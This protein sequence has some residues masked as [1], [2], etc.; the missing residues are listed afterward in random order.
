MGGQ[1]SDFSSWFPQLLQGLGH[2]VEYSIL[3]IV[4]ATII[5]L[6][7][8]LMR[9]SRF[10][11]WRAIS[12]VY[13]EI[14]RGTPLLVQLTFIVFGLSQAMPVLNDIFGAKSYP[15]I[16]AAAGLALNEGAYITEIV[17]AGILGVDR[18][19]R[20]AAESIG[21]TRYQ[22]MRYII[23]PQA[24]K[25]MIPPL[26]NQFAQ[27]IKDTSLLAPIGIVELMYQGQIVVSNNF[28]SFAVYG[29]VAI[30]YFV[31]IFIV[32]RIAGYLERRLQIDQR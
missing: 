16:G 10:W 18:G 1:T 5:G 27:T 15:L 2:T 8:A 24:F 29:T 13:V 14:F 28:Q 6:I 9:L 3:A 25:R 22:T 12:T 31:V 4:F 20:E 7:V 21:M 11:L 26:V 17:R 23:L 32:T 19:Q 30:L